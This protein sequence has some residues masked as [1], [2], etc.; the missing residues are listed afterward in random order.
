VTDVIKA[1]ACVGLPAKKFLKYL[2]N[3]HKP[4]QLRQK[5]RAA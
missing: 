3:A 4:V 2:L 1:N 5:R